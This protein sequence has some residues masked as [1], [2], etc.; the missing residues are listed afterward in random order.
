VEHRDRAIDSSF[1]FSAFTALGR[2]RRIGH[3]RSPK[4]D[5][6]WLTLCTATGVAVD[7]TLK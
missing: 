2:A 6:I 3:G 5:R 4:G 7:V 1:Q